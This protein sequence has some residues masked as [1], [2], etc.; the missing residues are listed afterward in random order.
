LPIRVIG[1]VLN[2]VRVGGAYRY[3]SYIYGY[4]AA[5]EDDVAGLPAGDR[6]PSA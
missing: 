4:M 6:R 5:E 3:Y 1:A 2:D